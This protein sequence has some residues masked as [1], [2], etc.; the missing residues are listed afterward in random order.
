MGS[1]EATCSVCVCGR[2]SAAI[3][4]GGLE[5]AWQCGRASKMKCKVEKVRYDEIYIT[6]S[7]M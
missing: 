4:N 7:M 5:W 3:R 2:V 6:K 1:R